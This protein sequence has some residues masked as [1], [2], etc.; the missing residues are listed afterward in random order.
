MVVVLKRR[1]DINNAIWISLL[2]M[3]THWEQLWGWR[4]REREFMC[5]SES[6]REQ[7]LMEKI[8]GPEGQL[9]AVSADKL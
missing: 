8:A 9:I 6:E 7:Q 1:L 4:E 5:V 3:Y 2:P